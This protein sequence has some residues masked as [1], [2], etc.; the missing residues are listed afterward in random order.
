MI[1]RVQTV[2]LLLA[3]IA[4][5][6]I[7]FI[8]LCYFTVPEVSK[9][10][11]MDLY[12]IRDLSDSGEMLARPSYWL[13]SAILATLLELVLL[14]AIFL[15]KD[16]MKQL[17]VVHFSYLLEAGL[18][19]LL[20][21]NIDHSMGLLPVEKSSDPVTT[22]WIAWYTPVAAL[23]FSFLAARG[24]KKDEELVRSVDRLR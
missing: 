22:Y 19:V 10:F 11:A 24:I 20:I 1:Q 2:Y 12:T 23:A 3:A 15:Y 5:G 13:W 6:L 21:F 9:T 18:L 14:G 17:R 16:R 4:I 7:F 8:D